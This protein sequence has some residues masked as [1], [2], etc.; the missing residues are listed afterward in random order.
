MDHANAS[1]ADMPAVFALMN[2][3]SEYLALLPKCGSD[4]CRLNSIASACAYYCQ[5]V[6][7]FASLI[8]NDSMSEL[9]GDLYWSFVDVT[10]HCDSAESMA[11]SG[12]WS[13]VP[14]FLELMRD[15]T[16]D[17]EAWAID[18]Q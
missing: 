12:A 2:R 17:I 16:V 6:G 14:F 3:G 13:E 11:G 9:Y 8:D 10:T 7:T 4:K 15:A 1:G 18:H 5:A